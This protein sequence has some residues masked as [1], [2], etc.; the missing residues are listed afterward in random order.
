MYPGLNFANKV[1]NVYLRHSNAN[2]RDLFGDSN[3]LN[4]VPGD[5]SAGDDAKDC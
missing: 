5:L 1:G 2:G 3:M 4:L